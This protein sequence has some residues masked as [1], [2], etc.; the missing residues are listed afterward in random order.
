MFS[1]ACEYGI[2]ASIFVA[3][4]S[5][6]GERSSLKEIAE[7]INSPIAF[8]GKIL[9]L[10][11]KSDILESIKGAGGGYEMEVDSLA[12]VCLL[13]I[14]TA[15]DGENKYNGCAL[16]LQHCDENHPCPVHFEY[17]KIREDLFSMLRNATL[18]KMVSQKTSNTVY[19]K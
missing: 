4:Q 12:T 19:L 6:K 16:G 3:R 9:Q 13:D 17:R 11:A 8:T 1:K 7:A 15:I 2:R 10:L 5:E 18:L 14:V